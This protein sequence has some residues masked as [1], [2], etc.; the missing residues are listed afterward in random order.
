MDEIHLS[1][2]G[3]ASV[4]PAPVSRMMASFAAD[5]RDGVDINLGVGYVNE[6]T[7]PRTLIEDSLHEVIAHPRRHR[8]AL[9]YG[10]PKGS[11]NLIT[12]IRDFLTRHKIGNLNEQVLNRN[13]IIIGP[14]GATSLLEA[15]AN[16]LGPRKA[17]T[18][19]LG[20]VIMADPVYYIYSNF[21]E[22]M[23]FEIVAVPESG[24][25][26]DIELLEKQLG[27]L[28]ERKKDI[29]FVYIVTVSNPTCTILSSSCQR[30]L[31][32]VTNCLS[33]DLGRKV[34]LFLDKAYENL[35]HDPNL[36]ERQSALLYDEQGLVYELYTLSKILA[37]A[38]RI[39]YMIGPGCAFTKAMIQRTSDVGFSAPLV[40]QEIASHILDHHVTGQ[41][42]KVKQGYHEK[43]VQTKKWID[44]FLGDSITEC[45]G[46]QAGFYYYLTFDDIETDEGSGFFK[47]L[48]RSTG[49]ADIDG[50]AKEKR[51]RVLYIP[52]QHCVHKRGSL[53]EIGKRQFRLSY[54]FEELDNIHKALQMMREAVA[55]ARSL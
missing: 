2:Y 4:R 46:G 54:G 19:P 45:R 38:L 50:P 49:R 36:P 37:P 26:I 24:E 51:P 53:T 23:G 32:D 41:I 43:A 16:I 17:G 30:Q 6:K 48:T 18:L 13:E 35:I 21:L 42:E 14:S 3:D 15:I 27:R 39:G 11:N 9:N 47:F 52:G 40:C 25:G 55:Y 12:S 34:P 31:I 10:G 29:S 22:R 20:L 33:S 8:A 1:E 7:I 28:G 44:E 5:F